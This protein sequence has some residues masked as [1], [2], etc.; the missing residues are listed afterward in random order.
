MYSE[1]QAAFTSAI[2]SEPTNA[3]LP[4]L[5]KCRPKLPGAKMAEFPAI[6]VRISGILAGHRDQWESNGE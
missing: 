2:I 5:F 1:I 4:M 3:V 6:P